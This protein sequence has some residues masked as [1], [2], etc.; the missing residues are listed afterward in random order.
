MRMKLRSIRQ[1]RGMTIKETADQL[2]CSPSH[3]GQIESGDKNPGWGLALRIKQLFDYYD[4][5]IFLDTISPNCGENAEA[6]PKI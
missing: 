2:R 6:A 1:E 3:Y 5:N 4:D